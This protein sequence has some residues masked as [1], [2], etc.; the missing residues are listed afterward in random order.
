M[1]QINEIDGSAA[2]LIETEQELEREV[3][4]VENAMALVRS[5]GASVVSVANLRFGEQVLAQIR[6]AGGDWGVRLEAL[7]WPEDAGC[8]LE[9]R[10][11]DGRRRSHA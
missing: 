1:E 4:E 3:A 8:D 2:R 9:V 10:R 11:V 6:A 7:P 5:G